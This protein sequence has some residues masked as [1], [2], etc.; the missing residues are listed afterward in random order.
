MGDYKVDLQT[1]DHAYQVSEVAIAKTTT[2]ADTLVCQI[3]N[4]EGLIYGVFLKLNVSNAAI[5][6]LID[7]RSASILDM[8]IGEMSEQ[9]L[10]IPSPI[11]PYIGKCDDDLGAYNWVWTPRDAAIAAFSTSFE[12]Y[13]AAGTVVSG[14]VVYA[15]R[16]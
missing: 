1:P 6:A 14:K 11:F 9:G 16:P 10:D 12:I 5:R 3:L 4:A 2:D 13:V 15:I 8:S 7:G